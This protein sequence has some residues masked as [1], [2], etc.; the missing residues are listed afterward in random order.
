MALTFNQPNRPSQPQKDKPNRP[1]QP[2]KDKPNQPSQQN[3]SNQRQKEQIYKQKE[4]LQQQQEQL[5]KRLERLSDHIKKIS[6]LIV[7]EDNPRDLFNQIRPTLNSMGLT[8]LCDQTK[9]EI[10][11]GHVDKDRSLYKILLRRTSEIN[12][13]IIERMN[14]EKNDINVAK[15]SKDGIEVYIWS[16]YTPIT[17]DQSV[18]GPVITANILGDFKDIIKKIF[19]NISI[20]PKT[21]EESIASVIKILNKYPDSYKRVSDM[22]NKLTMAQRSASIPNLEV[23]E[24]ASDLLNMYDKKVTEKDIPNKELVKS[25]FNLIDEIKG[26][27]QDLSTK[28]R[29]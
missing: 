21:K 10:I 11:T 20:K 9:T 19:P 15:W 5:D 26:K 1:S 29:S 2:Q 6:A 14:R 24:L 12:S 13:K 25:I 28:F 8:N 7:A 27:A 23:V 16:K 17:P 22:M 4:R 3:D 18:P